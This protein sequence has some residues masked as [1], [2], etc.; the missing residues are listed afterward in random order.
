M[1]RLMRNSMEMRSAFLPG[2][3]G[4]GMESRQEMEPW[5]QASPMIR[6]VLFLLLVIVA[7]CATRTVDAQRFSS[8]TQRRGLGNLYYTGTKGEFHY[9]AESY[10]LK[11]THHYRLP[12]SAYVIT[13]TFAKTSDRTLWIPWQVN[14]SSGTEGFRGEQLHANQK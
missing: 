2:I 7:G 9:F 11:P 10:F 3:S 1:C 4:R 13:N 6:V 14:L 5:Q 12:A 8:L